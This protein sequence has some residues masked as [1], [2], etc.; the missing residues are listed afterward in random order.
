MNIEDSIDDLLAQYRSEIDKVDNAIVLLLEKRAR[1][2]VDIGEVK[3]LSK[4]RLSFIA[5][6]RERAILDRLRTKLDLFPEPALRIIY[7]EI[8]AAMLG[9]M[10]GE[11]AELW[12]VENL[13]P[14][15]FALKSG[16]RILLAV[17]SDEIERINTIARLH[18]ESIR[19]LRS[20]SR[21]SRE[22]ASESA[23]AS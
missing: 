14:T 17:G 7:R 3:K 12:S 9:V 16:D 21:S 5:P 23:P 13:S 1:I 6:D 22:D 11:D 4:V 10:L 18:N 2:A 15:A 19:S 20:S 8:F